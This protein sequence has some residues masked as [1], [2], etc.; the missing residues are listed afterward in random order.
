MTK[1]RV[2][3]TIE[4]G[5]V[6]EEGVFH[7]IYSDVFNINSLSYYLLAND[8]DKSLL[9]YASESDQNGKAFSEIEIKKLLGMS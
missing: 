5:E 6:D 2:R 9:F 7:S 4:H 3:I 8:K 1:K